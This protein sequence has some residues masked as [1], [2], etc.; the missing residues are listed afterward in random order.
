MAGSSARKQSVALV[1][2]GVA[3]VVLMFFISWSFRADNMIAGSFRLEDLQIC[4]E[5]DEDMKPLNAGKS[6]QEGIKQVCLWFSYS[7]AREGDSL[8]IN[9]SFED[10]PIQKDVFRIDNAGGMR[11]FYLLMEDGSPLP[12]GSYSVELYCNGRSRAAEVF[13]INPSSDDVGS[14]QYEFMD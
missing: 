8:E 7:S 11:A 2:L 3:T 4:E 5:L 14:E 12:V 1:M 9:W 6:V 13:L 10:K